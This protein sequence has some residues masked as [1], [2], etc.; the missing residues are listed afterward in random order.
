MNNI[1][2]TVYIFFFN[3]F[4][5][6]KTQLQIIENDCYRIC[7][8]PKIQLLYIHFVLVSNFK[9]LPIVRY[10]LVLQIVLV[11]ERLGGGTFGGTACKRFPASPSDYVNTYNYLRYFSDNSSS[12]IDEN[13]IRIDHFCPLRPLL[14]KLGIPMGPWSKTR[15]PPKLADSFRVITYIAICI[16]GL[17]LCTKIRRCRS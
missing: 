16:T 11:H 12:C 13:N 14:K 8:I 7:F 10:I 6:S 17:F 3:F 9:L 5:K 2:L 1:V 4:F 15:V